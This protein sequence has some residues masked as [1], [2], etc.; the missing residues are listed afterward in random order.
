MP[1][2]KVV[3]LCTVSFMLFAVFDLDR[4]TWGQTFS[5]F[6]SGPNNPCA[7][8]SRRRGVFSLCSPILNSWA[9]AAARK[10]RELVELIEDA[11][12][13]IEGLTLGHLCATGTVFLNVACY[14]CP[15]RGR[16]RLT[17]LI[18]RYG[19]IMLLSKLADTLSTDCP[20][21]RGDGYFR[22]CGVYF[23]NAKRLPDAAPGSRSV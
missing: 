22:K 3:T 4:S 20:N 16:Y 1:G 2:S 7:P 14:R 8:A 9:I 21:R 19:P 18:D 5:D 17:R 10:P 6:L 23:P 15:R 13:C 12:R 11:N